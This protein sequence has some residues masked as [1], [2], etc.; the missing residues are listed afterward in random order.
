MLMNDYDIRNKASSSPS[1]LKIKKAATAEACEQPIGYELSVP[2][3]N[4]H[5]PFALLMLD[6]AARHSLFEFQLS[7]P[8]KYGYSPA[9]DVMSRLPARHV[10]VVEQTPFSALKSIKAQEQASKVSFD[11]F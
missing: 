5:G 10:V 2:W 9:R 4:S 3:P 11:F 7:E 6:A 8:R 1:L